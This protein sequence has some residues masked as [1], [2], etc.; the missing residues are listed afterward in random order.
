MATKKFSE[1]FKILKKKYKSD[2]FIDAN[3]KNPFRIL[4]SCILSLRTKDEVTLPATER[5]FKVAKTPSQLAKL[6]N[7]KI[8]QLIYPTGFYKKKSENIKQISNILIKKYN[9][10]VPK[11]Q[12]ELLSIKGVGL[13]TA[14]LVLSKAYNIPAI[15]VDTHV[16]R[17]S[18]RLGWVKT[19]TPNETEAELSKILPKKFWRDI[20]YMFVM[21]GKETCKP[22]GPKCSRCSI[23]E[24]CEFGKTQ[25]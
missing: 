1:I 24:Y 11:T 19:K 5:L 17:I 15:C 8:E 23:L 20:N 21:H 22:R 25:S 4:I 6:P 3:T 18:N 7:K 14:N 12:N 13:K 2:F 9:S 16:H 10:K